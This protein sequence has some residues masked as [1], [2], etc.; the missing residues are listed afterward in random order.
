[1]GIAVV[2][3]RGFTPA[4]RTADAGI[5]VVSEPLARQLWPTGDGVGQQVRL[6]APQPGSPD[7]P[8]VSSAEARSAKVG[9]SRT[10]HGRRRRTRSGKRFR[11]NTPDP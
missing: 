2:S 11:G 3:G 9:P 6:E 1:M 8:S 4:E 10:F 7:A 5:V